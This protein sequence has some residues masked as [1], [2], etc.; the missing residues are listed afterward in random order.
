MNF[1]LLLAPNFQFY[2]VFRIFMQ[3]MVAADLRDMRSTAVV[4]LAILLAASVQAGPLIEALVTK[5]INIVDS[6]DP[7]TGIHPAALSE[8]SI[9]S[10]K[11][12]GTAISVGSSNQLLSVLSRLGTSQGGSVKLTSAGGDSVN[13][14]M[15]AD[16]GTVEANNTTGTFGGS[17][18][19]PP[20]PLALVSGY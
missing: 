19:L 9:A 17:G 6:V 5:V 15:T 13:G 16:K 10:N 2:H 8:F 14:T 4:G 11:T 7:A 18:F 3:G 1:R 20:Q 12:A